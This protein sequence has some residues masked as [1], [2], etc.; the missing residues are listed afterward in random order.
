MSDESIALYTETQRFNQ[1]WVRWLIQLLA[2]LAWLTFLVQV[3][4]DRPVGNV[5]ASDWALWILLLVMGVGLPWL[6]SA[7]KM[8]TRVSSEGIEI[9]FSPFPTRMIPLKSIESYQPR[10]YRP[11][12]EYGGWGVRG[13]FGHGMAYNV[14]GNR[15]VQLVLADGKRLLIG[16]QE[17]DRLAEAIKTAMETEP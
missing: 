2:L 11:I 4:F 1:T 6:F 7:L 13:C 12:R 15:G 5:P 14:S 10:T 17:P 9:D 3:V 8:T 16:S